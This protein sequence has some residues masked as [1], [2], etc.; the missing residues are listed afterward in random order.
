M[1]VM[2]APG[3]ATVDPR[4]DTSTSPPG[5]PHELTVSV[6]P[7]SAGLAN[8]LRRAQPG[9]A[10]RMGV[11]HNLEAGPQ[12]TCRQAPAQRHHCPP[13][14]VDGL[15]D[16]LPNC[17]VL[18]IRIVGATTGGRGQLVGVEGLRG[19]GSAPG[20]PPSPSA[21][22]QLPQCSP[23]PCAPGQQRCTPPCANVRHLSLHL[24]LGIAHPKHS[25][26]IGCW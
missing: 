17:I 7:T 13:E 26:Q 6:W 3:V 25:L 2:A 18:V 15:G 16:K 4:M 8:H 14:H 22:L 1:H 24:S 11:L 23:A 21:A 12:P 5:P 19:W 10:W 9:T 20:Q